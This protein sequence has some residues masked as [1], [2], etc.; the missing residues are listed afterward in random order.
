L[1]KTPPHLLHPIAEHVL[2]SHT[3]PVPASAPST[4]CLL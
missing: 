3:H 4:G 2:H 1:F